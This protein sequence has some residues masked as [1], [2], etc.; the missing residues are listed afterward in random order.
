MALKTT[1]PNAATYSIFNADLMGSGVAKGTHRP[2][3][4]TRGTTITVTREL[5][6]CNWG[7][8]SEKVIPAGVYRIIDR[9]QFRGGCQ[10]AEKIG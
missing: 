4:C 6:A 9:S 1:T 2:S 10:T 3:E 8:G 7:K 5:E